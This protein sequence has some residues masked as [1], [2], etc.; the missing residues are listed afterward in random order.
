MLCLVNAAGVYV[1]PSPEKQPYKALVLL[2]VFLSCANKSFRSKTII[3]AWVLFS[4]TTFPTP[5]CISQTFFGPPLWSYRGLLEFLFLFPL[6]PDPLILTVGVPFHLFYAPPWT[7]HL[8]YTFFPLVIVDTLQ[9]GFQRDETV[10]PPLLYSP[11]PS[12]PLLSV[13]LFRPA[14]FFFCGTPPPSVFISHPP[15]LLASH[16]PPLWFSKRLCSFHMYELPISLSFFSSDQSALLASNRV[17]SDSSFLFLAVSYPLSW[18]MTP[19]RVCF[20][21]SP[22]P[23]PSL[24]LLELFLPPGHSLF[25]ILPFLFFPPPFFFFSAPPPSPG[26]LPPPPPLFSFFLW[27]PRLVQK[28][29]QKQPKPHCKKTLPSDAHI[30]PAHPFGLRALLFPLF[31]PFFRKPPFCPDPTPSPRSSLIIVV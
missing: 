8:L 3:P 11:L 14:H 18:P 22:S 30:F 5:P 1:L 21:F 12:F 6:P 25:P 17:F 9:R 4:I 7:P 28:Q 23:L 27:C 26:L 16:R 20:P 15:S 10:V 13:F 24:V 2:S 29:K 31:I 19:C